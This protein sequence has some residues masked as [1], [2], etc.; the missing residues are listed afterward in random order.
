MYKPSWQD[1]DTFAYA[2]SIIMCTACLSLIYVFVTRS[3]EA[4]L[5]DRG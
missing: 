2:A 5:P 4:I 1:V 3:C